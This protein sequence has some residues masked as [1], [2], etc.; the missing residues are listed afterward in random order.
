MSGKIY[1]AGETV[2]D[3]IFKDGV[4]S[5]G[6]PGGSV[7]NSMA[8]LGR[9][10]APAY[11]ISETGDDRAG[12]LIAGFLAANGVDTT[13][14]RRDSA[15]KTTLALAFLDSNGNSDYDFYR[16][17][18]GTLKPIQVPAFQ[19]EDIFLLASF[20]SIIPSNRSR[21]DALLGSAASGNA[22]IIYDPNFRK[23]HLPML[24]ELKPFIVG[25]IEAADVVR[26]S[27][28]DFSLIFGAASHN[29]ALEIAGDKKALVYTMGSKGVW[30]HSNSIE[31]YYPAEQIVPVSTIGAGDNFNAAI[32][33]S[34][35]SKGVTRGTLNELNEGDWDRIIGTGI[36]FSKQ[37]CLSSL[38]YIDEDYACQYIRQLQSDNY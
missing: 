32:A 31:K 18:S 3:I 8:T 35:Y 13:Y 17:G 26:A 19:K 14:I 2:Y 25:N 22:L 20:Y 1:G 21:V 37:V 10:G 28:E 15:M 30:L 5:G 6:C 38:N 16:N 9:L 4:V 23:P 24:K 27:D 29:E 7:L 12:G 36:D 33:F 34:L 11:F